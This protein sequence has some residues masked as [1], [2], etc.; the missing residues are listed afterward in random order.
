VGKSK[1]YHRDYDDDEEFLEDK[2]E[3][4]EEAIRRWQRKNR[5]S[6]KEVTLDTTIPPTSNNFGNQL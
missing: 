4:A 2:S 6:Q 1:H 5:R 3:K